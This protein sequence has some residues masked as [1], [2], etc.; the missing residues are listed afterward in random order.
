[1]SE[2]RI[3]SETL[4]GI[5]DAIREKTGGSALIAPEDMATEIASISGGGSGYEWKTYT[6]TMSFSD[7]L[8]TLPVIPV[9][10]SKAVVLL[11]AFTIKRTGT[12]ADGVVTY[13]DVPT[14]RGSQLCLGYGINVSPLAPDGTFIYR[15]GTSAPTAGETTNAFPIPA[16]YRASN[17]GQRLGE[18]SVSPDNN[19]FI[20]SRGIPLQLMN[21][22]R[23][24]C[25][26]GLYMEFEYTVKMLEEVTA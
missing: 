24:F 17:S 1:M 10:S 14:N 22:T 11:V 3:Q 25:R 4:E 9:D 6:G 15:Y 23:A 19:N 13:D 2:Y 21:G 20:S 26:T 7:E 8:V 12:V 18:Y 5:A 16:R